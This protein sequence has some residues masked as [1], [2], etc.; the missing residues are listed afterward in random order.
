MGLHD[1]RN[2]SL[3]KKISCY[4]STCP[5]AGCDMLGVLKGN[6]YS[7]LVFVD[8]LLFPAAFI[9]LFLFNFKSPTV[10]NNESW[11]FKILLV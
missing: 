7:L 4:V 6:F 2:N 11:R 1:Y 3:L 10:V 8:G 5:V 9:E